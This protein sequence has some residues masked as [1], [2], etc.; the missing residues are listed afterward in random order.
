MRIKHEP[1]ILV[2]FMEFLQKLF[3]LVVG[4]KDEGFRALE[5]HGRGEVGDEFG[6]EGEGAMEIGEGFVGGVV[7]D[8]EE[9]GGGGREGRGEFAG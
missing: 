6:G 5:F 8:E 4:G 9:G 7:E 2:H 3:A 1:Y